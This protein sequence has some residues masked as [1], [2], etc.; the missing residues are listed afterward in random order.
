MECPESARRYKEQRMS[1]APFSTLQLGR[2]CGDTKLNY[3]INSNICVS[4][5]RAT[6]RLIHRMKGTKKV[7]TMAHIHTMILFDLCATTVQI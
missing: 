1:L 7:Q 2:G 3:I 4:C 6:F 5:R